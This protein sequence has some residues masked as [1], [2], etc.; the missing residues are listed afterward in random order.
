MVNM[1]PA[2]PALTSLATKVNRHFSGKVIFIV[3]Q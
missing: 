3:I 1:M 2:T